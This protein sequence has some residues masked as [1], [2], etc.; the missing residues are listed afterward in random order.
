VTSSIRIDQCRTGHRRFPQQSGGRLRLGP[1]ERQAKFI[2][3]SVRVYEDFGFE[4]RLPLFDHEL[5]DFWAR[6]AQLR[7]GRALY[8]NLHGNA[9]RCGHRRQS[10]P[11]LAGANGH[12]CVDGAGLRPVAKAAQRRLHRWRWQDAYD[13]AA[14][15]AG[16]G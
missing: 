5:M 9:R 16:A 6:A 11:Q 14:R 2:C 15:V 7:V 1:A 4:W 10:G 3:S 8:F 13:G 12:W